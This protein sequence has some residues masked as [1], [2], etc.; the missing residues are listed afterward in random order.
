MKGSKVTAQLLVDLISSFTSKSSSSSGSLLSQPVI[1]YPVTT[2]VRGLIQGVEL[3][4][5]SGEESISLVAYNVQ[6]AVSS[7]LISSTSSSTFATPLTASQSLYRA[8]QPR[9]TIGPGGLATCAFTSGYAQLS[10][11]QWANNPY[12]AS[13]AVKSPLLRIAVKSQTEVITT[14]TSINSQVQRNSAAFSLPGVPAYYIALQFSAMQNFNFS[15]ISSNS[16]AT[17]KGKSNFT[18]PACT[19]YNGMAYVP[20][21][22]CNI[23]SFTNFNVTYSCFDSTQLCPSTSVRRYLQNKEYDST[24]T[25]IAENNDDDDDEEDYGE[26]NVHEITTGRRGRYLAADDDASEASVSSSTYGVLLQSIEAEFSSVLSSNPFKLDVAQSTVVL[27]FVGCLGGFIVLML[28]YL[29]RLDRDEKLYKVY[30]KGAA[31]ALARSRLEEELSKGGKGDSGSSFHKHVKELNDSVRAG[32]SMMSILHRS[33]SRQEINSSTKGEESQDHD[34]DAEDESSVAAGYDISKDNTGQFMTVA[35]VTEFVHYLFPGK[36]IFGKKTNIFGIIAVY[37][38]YFS[39]LAGSTLG[40]SRTI[41]FLHL[42]SAVLTVIFVDTVFFGIYFPGN[43]TCTLMTDKVRRFALSTYII[44]ANHLILN[45]YFLFAVLNSLLMQP[46][47]IEA[48]SKVQSGASQCIWDKTELSCSLRPAP[49][50]PIFTIIVAL[51]TAI[52]SIP[53][54]TMLNMALD[55]YANNRPGSRSFED[56][57]VDVGKSAE[58]G[59]NNQSHI[60]TSSVAKELRNSRFESAFADEIKRGI[61]RGTAVDTN[62]ASDISQ[63]AYAG[64]LLAVT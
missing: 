34:T 38:D 53:I 58:G 35:V 25:L 43:S 31:D 20:C 33:T 59:K 56:D 40:Q 37:H 21:K 47:C 22:G 8:I 64:T 49:S 2:A 23:S 42:T 52:M 6:V 10:V 36:S 4:M 46:S 1:S 11:L 7:A 16:S 27:T 62:T 14:K 3:G 45:I 50:D 48:P 29:S 55:R 5:A 54:L 24:D 32:S 63:I 30:V 17:S 13:T 26:V 28:I 18:L 61:S 12:A 41:R 60:Q 57:L 9:I 15:A 39:M 44:R 51:L 19:L